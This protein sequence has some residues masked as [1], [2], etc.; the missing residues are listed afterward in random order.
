MATTTA[1][2]RKNGRNGTDVGTRLSSVRA[3]LDALQQDVR[4]LMSCRSSITFWSEICRL[5]VRVLCCRMINIQIMPS[6]CQCGPG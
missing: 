3:D 5:L 6:V 2:K 1:R 4:G